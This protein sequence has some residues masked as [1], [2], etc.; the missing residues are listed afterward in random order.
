MVMKSAVAG[1]LED[2]DEVNDTFRRLGKK[3]D[4]AKRV[5]LKAR[6]ES[7]AAAV[8]AKAAK[9]GKRKR[10]AEESIIQ[11]NDKKAKKAKQKK[12]E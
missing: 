1:D 4:K 2:S 5:G 7:E 8:T 6:E 3:A 10:R 12:A 9:K 11:D